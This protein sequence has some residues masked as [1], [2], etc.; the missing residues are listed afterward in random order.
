MKRFIAGLLIMML[1]VSLTAPVAE[2]KQNRG[3]KDVGKE[4]DWA[5]FSIEKMY[6]KGIVKGYPG[7]WFKP[8][9]PVTHLEAIVMA[10]RI[11]GWEDEID[12][13][14]KLPEDITKFKLSWKDAYYY[15]GLAVEKG[16]VKPEELRNFNP[17]QPAKRYEVAKYIVRAI[18]KE[19]EAKE[20]MNEKLTFKDAQAIPKDAVGYVY[21]MVDMGLMK[22]Y[23]GQVFQPSKTVNRAEMAVIIN[24]LDEFLK[25]DG[26]KESVITTTAKGIVVDVEERKQTVS[27]LTYDKVEK[28]YVGVLKESDIEGRHLELETEYD[29]FVL[30][31][32]TDRLEDYVGEKIVVLGEVKHGA[33]IYM[34]GP[35]LEVDDW[36]VVTDKNTLTFEVTGETYI[37]IGGKRAELSELEEGS[38]V[39]LAAQKNEAISIKVI[40]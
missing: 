14:S 9:N 24:S 37:E 7:G 18:G 1:V 16:I 39:E 22:G 29:S 20:H 2:A 30:V 10:L 8:R 21:V 17:N 13:N 36:F 35:L 31:G 12:R 15:L 25:K 23:P 28:G 6:A 40:K 5:R 32:D 38:Y 33:S 11:M 19:Q 27:L 3:F 26:E 4:W 34:R